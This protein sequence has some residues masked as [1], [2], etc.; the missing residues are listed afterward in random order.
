MLPSQDGSRPFRC[1]WTDYGDNCLKVVVDAHFQIKPVGEAYHE[2]R[3]RVLVAIDQAVKK[4]SLQ[5]C[6]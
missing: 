5:F 1:Y 3:Q 6:S 4:N 2:N